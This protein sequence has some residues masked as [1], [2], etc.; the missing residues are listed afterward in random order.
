MGVEASAF[1]VL[2]LEP[3]ANGA[4]VDEAYRRLIK[5]YHP[6]RSGGDAARAADINRAYFELR[7]R[8]EIDDPAQ[9][10]PPGDIGEA[11]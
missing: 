10:R 11:I 7:R 1:T 2:G 9:P 8:G 5:L 6:D 4:A 3:G